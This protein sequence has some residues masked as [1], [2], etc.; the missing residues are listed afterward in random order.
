MAA[1]ETIRNKNN[2]DAVEVAVAA[3]LHIVAETK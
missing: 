2:Q 1:M 3:W